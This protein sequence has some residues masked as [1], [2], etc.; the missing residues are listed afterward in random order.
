M[1]TTKEAAQR[2][3]ISMRRVNAL[4]AS[5]DLEA[6]RF[7]R[8]WMLDER[9]VHERA[10]RG[11]TAGR[12]KMNEKNERNLAPFTLMNRNHPVLDFVY[13]RRT[14][15]TADIVPREGIAWKPLGIGLRER[16]PNRYDLAAWIASRSIP[17]MRPNLAPVLRELAARH[18]ID[19]MF[20]SWGLNLSDQYWFKPVDI[21]VDWHDVNY[22]ENGYEEALGET[23]L[24]GSAPAGNSTARITHSPDT[25]T[26][27]ML[28]KTWIHRDGTN[29]LV[30]SG[31]GNENREPYNELL[32]TKLLARLLDDED[33]VAYSLTERHGR[34]Y[35]TCP[36]FVT[37]ETELIPAADVLTAFGVTEGR[38]LHRGYLEA[39]Q[40]LGVS[41]LGRA[42]SKMIVA[43]HL[44]AN[45]DRHTHNFGLMREVETLDRYRVAP[46]FDNGCGFYS[47]ATTDELEHG[48]YLWEAHPFRPYPSQQLALVE[49]LSWYDSSSL[50]GFLDDIADVL[51]LN[52]QLDERFIEAVQRQ[53]AKQIETV[54]DLAAE[55]RL[56]FPGR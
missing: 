38:D 31:T 16:T 53:T 21:D 13:N 44:M 37:S 46:L 11:R 32:A 34:A 51:S 8:S 40:A 18:G 35:S 14:R 41:N 9:S 45:F 23:L 49:D 6:Q 50:D 20:D 15:E 7:G 22:F 25:A 55:R 5:G 28:S 48:R 47:R 36:T 56:L 29:L 19:L 33:F 24:G 52:A 26:P 10:E 39:G 17:D 12:P 42:V 1:Y 3:G 4:V 54:N 2:L 30:K 27:G 43:D